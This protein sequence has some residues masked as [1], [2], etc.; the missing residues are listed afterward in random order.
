MLADCKIN[1]ERLSQVG[2]ILACHACMVPR[3]VQVRK[4]AHLL[5]QEGV[6]SEGSGI[7]E[8]VTKSFNKKA[9]LCR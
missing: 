5:T 4:P 3:P 8:T 1:F 2:V 6:G 9:S 7:L